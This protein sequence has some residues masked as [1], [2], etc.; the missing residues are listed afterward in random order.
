MKECFIC[1]NEADKKG[2][3]IVPHFL[4]KRI[5]N[6]EGSK[7]RDKELGFEITE[8]GSKSYFGCTSNWVYQRN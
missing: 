1:N 7:E 5:D 2:S 8:T 6:E 3:H 4:M